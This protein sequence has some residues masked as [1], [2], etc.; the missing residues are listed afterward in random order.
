[1]VLL[2]MVM[3]RRRM[4]TLLLL[5]LMRAGASKEMSMITTM[6]DVAIVGDVE[7]W[8]DD[9]DKND[10]YVAVV[11]DDEKEVDNGDGDGNVAF[12][13]DDEGN[14]DYGNDDFINVDGSINTDEVKSFCRR[15]RRCSSSTLT[16]SP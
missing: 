4:V 5:V 8:D 10:G 1:M 12:V 2:M 11:V 3:R 9:Y 13:G 6:V 15:L 7:E 14:D 16:S